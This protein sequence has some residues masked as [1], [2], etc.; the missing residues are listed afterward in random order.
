M[1]PFHAVPE[2]KKPS[3]KLKIRPLFSDKRHTKRKRALM[4]KIANMKSTVSAPDLRDG[5]L[6]ALQDLFL[7]MFNQR[8]TLIPPEGVCDQPRISSVVGFAG[9]LTGCLL[10]HFNPE[11][12][13]ALAGAL[14]GTTILKVDETV[15]DAIGEMVNM[16][17]GGLKHHVSKE[18]EMFKISIPSVIAGQDY[19]T[20][21]PADAQ[22]LM[23]GVSAG[24]YK[25]KL[26]LVIEG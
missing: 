26:Q 5:L 3:C 19:A 7:N 15:C 6:H 8:A 4:Q 13:C 2:L 23:V 9:R 11:V 18:E 17:A 14:L 12:A 25:F 22:I 20:H 1:K 24:P 16:L 10:L 21:A